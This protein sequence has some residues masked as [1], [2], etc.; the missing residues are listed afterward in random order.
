M[1]DFDKLP[2]GGEEVSIGGYKGIVSR[3]QKIAG[4]LEVTV[5]LNDEDDETPISGASGGF[6]AADVERWREEA[7]EEAEDADDEEAE[8]A[9]QNKEEANKAQAAKPSAV[10]KPATPAHKPATNK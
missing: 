8:N 2:A 4:G 3:V 1:T 9:K 6:S 5:Q 7:E 10:S